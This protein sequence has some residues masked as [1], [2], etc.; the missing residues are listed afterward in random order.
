MK[1]SGNGM[2]QNCMQNLLRMT[3]GEVRFDILRG[4]ES[5][6]IDLPETF[7]MAKAQT[8]AY[9][10][11]SNYEPRIAF[12]GTELVRMIEAGEFELTVKGEKN[13]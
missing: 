5:T 9:W 7:A 3:R 12:D 11:A 6:I 2:P 8:G 13:A 10:L 4:M 1:S